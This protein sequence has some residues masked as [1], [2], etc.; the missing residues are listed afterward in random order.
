LLAALHFRFEANNLITDDVLLDLNR[1]AADYLRHIH[2]FKYANKM[3]RL[4]DNYVA[5]PFM[6]CDICGNYPELEISIIESNGDRTLHVG[7]SC[8]DNLTGQNFSERMKNF[9]KKRENIMSNRKRIEQLTSILAAHDKRD[10][11]VKITDD[12][13]KK[14]RTI[15]KQLVTAENLTVQQQQTADTYLTISFGI[16]RW[17]YKI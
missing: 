6:K 12:D 17:H 10:S 14:I 5:T 8:I 7:N 13:A 3:Y 1:A 9:R 4:V 15:L 2:P 16:E 11:S